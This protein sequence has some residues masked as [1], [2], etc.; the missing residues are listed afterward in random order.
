MSPVV[1]RP[2]PSAGHSVVVS[3]Y[4]LPHFGHFFIGRLCLVL[5]CLGELSAYHTVSLV[6]KPLRLETKMRARHHAT[7]APLITPVSY[8]HLRAHETPEHLVCR[9][10][11][12]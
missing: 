11:L 8:T 12:E 5:S 3:G 6:P 4:S 1:S 9:L 10:L 7:P 2:L